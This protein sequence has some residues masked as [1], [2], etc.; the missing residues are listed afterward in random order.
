MAPQIDHAL[1]LLRIGR[2]RTTE[3]S[4][5]GRISELAPILGF[6]LSFGERSQQTA[7]LRSADPGA[8]TPPGSSAALSGNPSLAVAKKQELQPRFDLVIQ[9]SRLLLNEVAA[10]I[11]PPHGRVRWQDLLDVSLASRV[12]VARGSSRRSRPKLSALSLQAKCFNE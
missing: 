9:N 10:G 12:L 3:C 4:P 8:A 7:A 1:F 5:L 6:V 2:E 11:L